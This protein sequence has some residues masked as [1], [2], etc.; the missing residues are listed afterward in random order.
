MEGG[1]KLGTIPGTCLEGLSK[2]RKYLSLCIGLELHRAYR[3]LKTSAHLLGHKAT[4]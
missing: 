2:P 4:S 1:L 3:E